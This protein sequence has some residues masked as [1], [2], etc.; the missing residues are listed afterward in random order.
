M[1]V[2]NVADRAPGYGMQGV[3]VDGND[4]PAVREAVREASARARRME[5]PTLVECKTYRLSG[6]SRGDPRV[7]RT[8]DEEAAWRRKCPIRR[9]RRLLIDREILTLEADRRIR[10]D[11]RHLVREAVRFA[12]QSPDPDPGTLEQGVFA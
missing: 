4:L 5:G 7:Y 11:A 2:E 3:V 12:E 1:S 8:K 6:H 9:F 10:K